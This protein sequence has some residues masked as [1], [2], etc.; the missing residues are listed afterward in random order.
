MQETNVLLKMTIEKNRKI[1]EVIARFLGHEPTWKE[2]KMFNIM[3]SLG[4]SSIYYK[5]K[6]IGHIHY[7]TKDDPVI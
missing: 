6:L 5:G 2:R 3:N 7:E 4:E 1:K